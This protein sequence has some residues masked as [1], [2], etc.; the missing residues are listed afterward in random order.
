MISQLPPSLFFTPSPQPPSPPPISTHSE[1]PSNVRITEVTS[2]DITVLWSSSDSFFNKHNITGY[3]VRY[4]VF[5][6]GNSRIINVPGTDTTEITISGLNCNT[7]YSF[8]VAAVNSAGIGT[9]SNRFI[10]T[11]KG[12]HCMQYSFYLKLT[13]SFHFT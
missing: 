2:S 7:K 13:C 12:I 1:A 10:P 11:T 9:Y 4:K 6:S 5:E 3:S 8:E